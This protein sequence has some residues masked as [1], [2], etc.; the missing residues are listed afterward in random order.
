MSD[1]AAFKA[2]FLRKEAIWREADAFRQKYHPHGSLPVPVLDIAEFELGLELVPMPGLRQHHD[3]EALLVPGLNRV[4]VDKE[5]FVNPKQTFRLNF[6]VAHEIGHLILHPRQYQ[7]A[8]HKSLEQWLAFFRAI[9]EPE[10]RKIEWQANEFA[11]RLLVPRSALEERLATVVRKAR[12]AGFTF[13]SGDDATLEYV[14][15]ALN[16]PFEVS[17]EVM[18]RRLRNEELWPPS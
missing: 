16:R 13:G 5:G 6:S 4:Y 14:S 10:Y 2:K 8:S 15:N 9:P 17:W 7:G 1:P 3:I 18:I 11:G 12:A